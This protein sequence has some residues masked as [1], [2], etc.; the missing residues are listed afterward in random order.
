MTFTLD[1]TAPTVTLS[2]LAVPIRN[3]PVAQLQLTFD[4]A[5]ANLDLTDL[6]LTRNGSI[7]PI[8]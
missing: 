6:R 7:V 5:I 2:P 3:T 1:T 4:E 8:E